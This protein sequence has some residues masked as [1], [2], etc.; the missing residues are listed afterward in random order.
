MTEILHID[1]WSFLDYKSTFV[2][3]N[4]RQNGVW[5][6][7]TWIGDHFRRIQAYKLLE[8]YC[9]NAARYWL[10]TDVDED[11]R[12]ARREYGDPNVFL[13]TIKS[14]LL[15]DQQVIRV[16]GASENDSTPDKAAQ[17]HQ[18]KLN[19]WADK[20]RFSLKIIEG[21]RNSIRLGDGVYV[22]HWDGETKRPRVNVWDPG[23]YFPV[24]DPE[25]LTDSYPKKI[26]IAYE[27]ERE[28][29]GKPVNFVRRMTWELVDVSTIEDWEGPESYSHKWNSEPTTWTCLYSDGEWMVD[30]LKKPIEEFPLEKGGF[31]VYEDD[32][33]IDFIPI[34]HVPNTIAG[35]EHFGTSS[36]ATV[37]Q[38]F[39]DLISTDT[40]LQA[41]SATTGSP[42]IVVGGGTIQK[43]E[44]NRITTYGPGTVLEV[45]EGQATLVD[46]SKSLDALVTYDDHLLSRL[47][48]NGRIP[49]S[50]LGRIKPSEVPSG[51]ALT[52]SFAP[53]SSMIL[54]MRKV[55][56]DKYA[57]LLKFVSRYMLMNGD[58]SQIFP[59][60][61][62]FGTFLPADKKGT[63]E[64][65]KSAFDVKPNLV[66]LETAV[67]MLME[68][69]FPIEEAFAEVER[70]RSEDFDGTQAF[71]SAG[72]NLGEARKRMGLPP[73]S[74][75]DDEEEEEDPNE[76]LT[77]KL[78][79]P[80]AKPPP[81]SFNPAGEPDDGPPVN[82][83]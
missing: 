22:L 39:D 11:E 30:D 61:L 7:P 48:V 77:L 4:Q 71:L 81:P 45:G 3:K 27:F 53:H 65:L 52:L 51:I 70:I 74:I 60:R 83:R 79:Q 46:T 33:E 2:Q 68:A 80:G 1:P 41:S 9:R 82:V 25:D 34:V 69:G 23:F 16:D 38:I 29:N 6:N 50:L 44:D 37:M 75:E 49:E 42:P 32:L 35:V 19:E 28:M 24:L 26:H 43:D 36:L 47:S 17:E 40:D 8:S 72:A 5:I 78:N 18:K 67:R 20:E 55:R 10:G 66:S 54:E 63:I 12:R 62:I 13:E 73:V 15:G 64:I 58:V 21:E 14:S 31:S 57:L 59:A 56:D 76:G